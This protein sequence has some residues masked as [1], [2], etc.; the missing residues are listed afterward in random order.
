MKLW[1]RWTRL[2][3]AFV[4]LVVAGQG[5]RVCGQAPSRFYL[6]N[7]DRVVFYGDSITDQRLYTTFV[8]DYVV[9]RFPGLNVT[10]VHSGWGGDRVT[11]GGGGPIDVRLRRDVI[12]YKPA[13]MTIML[14]MND[15]GYRAFDRALFDT[16][17]QGY[18]HILD[19][20]RSALPGIRLTLIQPSPYDDVTRPPNFEG[21]YNAVLIRYGEWVKELGERRHLLVVDMNSPLV[22]TL[23]CAEK[24]DPDGAK[25]ILPDR[26][27]PRAGGHLV[28]AEALL[29]GWE[30]PALV[31]SVAMDAAGPR[32]V[33]AQNTRVSD[34]QAADQGWSWTQSD[35]ALPMPLDLADPTVKLALQCSDFVQALDQE[36]LKITGLKGERYKLQIDGEPVGEFTRQQ[37]EE[38]VN[39]ATFS[40]PM[41]KQAA[42]VHAL[43]V[44]HNDI[45]F[46]R[47]RNL[48][49]PLAGELLPHLGRALDDLDRL[50]NDVIEERRGAAAPRPHHYQL[51]AE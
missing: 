24:S 21:G 23:E 34:L 17:S 48:Q 22:R 20:V 8:E 6:K 47:W 35:R 33:S 49:V 5:A 10:F 44:K 27:H 15:A 50:E 32:L 30:A 43:T 38:G 41:E 37:L 40:T 51:M 39:L 12:A 36:T 16:Y 42:S 18:E 2:I 3:A 13:V 25:Q 28:M 45:H 7:G 29:K 11:G 9:T 46:A 14:G 1:Q 26:V 19:T 31:S 4:G